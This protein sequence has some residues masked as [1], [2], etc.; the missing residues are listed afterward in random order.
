MLAQ[1]IDSGKAVPGN[2]ALERLPDTFAWIK[3]GC[4]RF[5]KEEHHIRWY[6]QRRRRMTPRVIEQ[7]DIQTLRMGGGKV[8]QKVLKHG[9]KVRSITYVGST[10]S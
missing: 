6:N 5:L 3:L 8:V 7:Q 9:T 1:F 2:G 10:M 4:I